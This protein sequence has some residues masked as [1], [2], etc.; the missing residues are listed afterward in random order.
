[1]SAFA[2][3]LDLERIG[4]RGEWSGIGDDLT[5]GEAT[6]HV[7]AEN[8]FYIVERAGVENSLRAFADLLGGLQHDE[9][10]TG[11]R[12][13]RK[14]QRGTNGPRAVN[15]VAAGVHDPG[16]GGRERQARGFLD[17]QRVDVAPDR[18]QGRASI[19][20]REPGDD[21]RVRDGPDVDGA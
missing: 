14:Q 9:H 16:R 4:G 1:V 5:D 17:R 20:P 12:L 15:V 10:V 11:S 2:E 6:I 18:Y 19:A 3:E 13:A 8:G 7:S 21:A